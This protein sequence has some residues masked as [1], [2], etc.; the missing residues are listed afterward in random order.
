MTSSHENQSNDVPAR[1][2][3]RWRGRL[4]G[5]VYWGLVAVSLYLILAYL[6]LPAAWRHYEHHPSLESAPKTA[7]TLEGI[8]ADPLNVALAGEHDELIKALVSAGWR[9]ADPVTLRTTL[10][11]AASVFSG[12]NYSTAPV[13]NLFLWGRKQDLAFEKPVDGGA[14]RRHHV[15]FWHSDDPVLDGRS[16]WIG[17]A[18]FDEGVG[19]SHYTGE[20]THHIAPDVDAERDQLI[21]DLSEA[22]QLT[23]ISQVTGV[24]ATLFGRNG[25]GDRYFTDGELTVASLSRDNANFESPPEELPNPS[26]VAWKNDAWARLRPWLK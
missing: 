11:I 24:G 5:V 8:P 9:P 18:T 7:V 25:G 12:R 10:E 20:V 14:S 13:S 6:V 22:R 17:A 15:R 2:A 3:G 16:L 1:S 23:R 19:V 4:G 21:G 26:A